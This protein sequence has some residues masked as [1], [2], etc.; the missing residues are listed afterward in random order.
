[1]TQLH[2][3]RRK[4]SGFT[5]ISALAFTLVVGTVLAGVGT[6][7]M[8][9][10]SR[11]NVEGD[12][13]NAIALADGGV[14]YEIASI[15]R[16][17]QSGAGNGNIAG[18]AHQ[19]GAPYV[20]TLSGGT[21]SVYSTGWNG[22]TCT[23]SWNGIGDLCVVSTGAVNGIK[24]TVQ[25]HGKGESFF[26][27]Y[28]IYNVSSTVNATFNGLGKSDKDGI[29]G[30]MGS[31]SGVT[32]HGAIGSD[33]IAGTLYMNGP[34]A[35][36]PA[37]GGNVTH[38]DSAVNFPTVVQVAN[39]LF[40]A[41]GLAYLQTHNNNANIMMLKAGDPTLATEPTIAGITLADVQSKM[42][43]AGYTVASRTLSTSPLPVTT[44]TSTLD[45][46][47]TGTRFD[48]ISAGQGAKGSKVLFFPPGDYYFSDFNPNTT[49]VMLSH[50]GLVRFWIDSNAASGDSFIHLT[51]LITDTT[52]ATF[53]IYYNKC[54]TITMH[55]NSTFHGTVYAVKSGCNNGLPAV[56]MSGSNLW[57]GGLIANSF[58]VGGGSKVIFP[59]T[60]GGSSSDPSPWVGFKDGWKEIKA[61]NDANHTVFSDG[62]NN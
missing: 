46:G 1:M 51:V 26:D 12:Y 4:A 8:S 29:Q 9:H 5:L 25:V 27:D 16:G 36:S 19:S 21:Y 31:N 3:V 33:A 28:S 39:A 61:T 53:R 58:T 11:A 45:S 43:T 20:G 18:G 30:N 10:Y 40:P 62:T 55:G 41:G 50:L 49:L 57:Y 59:N 15:S 56:D 42:T 6:V 35:T 34:N 54:G 24:R 38:T 44:D 37:A 23:G 52:P 17:I 2:T 47:T 48:D 13:A 14:N 60:G 32:L 7:A 22:T